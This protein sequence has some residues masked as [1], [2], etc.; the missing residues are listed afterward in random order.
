[1]VL[2]IENPGF[3]RL[4]KFLENVGA[5]ETMSVVAQT[6]FALFIIMYES[7]CVS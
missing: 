2:F 7:L 6:D 4:E 5:N 1:M 3:F